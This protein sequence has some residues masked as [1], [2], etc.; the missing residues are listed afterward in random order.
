MH[1]LFGVYETRQSP[2]TDGEEGLRVL[3]V[4]Q[5]CQDAFDR[6]GVEIDFGERSA[7]LF[8]PRIRICDEDVESVKEQRS[9][10]C[11]TS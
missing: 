7:I 5:Q 8:C 1:A 3:T 9:G 4:L 11:R 10:M 2:L 6:S